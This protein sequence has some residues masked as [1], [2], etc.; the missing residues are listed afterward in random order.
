MKAK[1]RAEN[2]AEGEVRGSAQMV[3]CQW[4]AVRECASARAHA[5]VCLR[6]AFIPCI[7]ADATCMRGARLPLLSCVHPCMC[8]CLCP[9]S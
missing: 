1:T 4:P 8:V 6:A 9:L 2:E 3:S 5:C 7:F